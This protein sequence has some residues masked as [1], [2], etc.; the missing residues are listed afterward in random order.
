MRNFIR[1]L[2]QCFLLG[3]FLFLMSSCKKM[4][5]EG[6]TVVEGQAVDQYT[7]EPVPFARLFVMTQ[8]KSS[9]YGFNAT[10]LEK[11]AD[12]QG[13]FEFSF[14]AESDKN[15][16]L[17][18]GLENRYSSGI[19]GMLDLENASRNRKLKLK[20]K[21]FAWAKIKFINEPPLDTAWFYVSGTYFHDDN[22]GYSWFKLGM[23]HR[24]TVVVRTVQGGLTSQIYWSMQK[25]L[26]KTEHRK[27]YFFPALDTTLVEIRY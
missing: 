16:G 24:D 4:Q 8:T 2:L 1:L 25:G 9:F 23:Q 26:V 7:G 3:C 10:L 27:D 12:A 21:P 5:G 11:Q 13:K 18:G 22:R 6:R 17:L 20:M 15:Y 14:E 19:D